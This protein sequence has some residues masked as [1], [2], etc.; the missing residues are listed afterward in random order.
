MELV[1]WESKPRLRR[2]VLIAA[3]EGWSDAGEAASGAVSFLA[4]HLEARPFAWID[5]EGFYDFTETRPTVRLID[6]VTRTIDWPEPTFS[7]ASLP[8]TDRDVVLLGASEPHLKWRT[9]T[10]TVLGVVRELGIEMVLALGAL[11]SEVPHTRPVRVIGTSADAAIIAR[12][13]LQPSRYEGPTGILGVL[14]HAV[15]QAGIEAASLWASVPHYLP[16]APSPKA[17]LAL[18]ERAAEVL[19]ATIATVE[20]EIASAAYERQVSE[21]VAEEEEVAEYVR[22]LEEDEDDVD[23]FAEDEAPEIRPEDLPSGE[24]LAADVERFLR[25]QRDS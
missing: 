18:V 5:P 6:G 2:P 3:F 19:G 23:D 15:G 14:S 21:A 10:D 7:A 20:L 16:R 13:N 4:Q 8:G 12:L 9:F 17:S 1:R 24:E 22:R 25:D 11:L